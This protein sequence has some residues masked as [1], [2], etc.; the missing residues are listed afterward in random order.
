MSSAPRARVDVQLAFDQRADAAAGAVLRALLGVISGNLEGSLAGQDGEFLHQLRVSVRRSRTVQ[1]QLQ[2]VFPSRLLP[3]YR[4]EFRWLQRATGEARDLDVYLEG[5]AELCALVPD[6]WRGELEPLRMVLEH[7]RL[8]AHGEMTRALLSRRT[9]E[10]IG[11]WEML[12]ETLVELPAEDRRDARLPIGELAGRRIQRLY[13]RVV[14]LGE[15]IGPTS[16]AAELHELRKR[17]KELRY[18][19]E[20]FG[21]SLFAGE[22]VAAMITEVKALQQLL[23]RHQDR[24]VQ[25]AMLRSV[26]DEVAVLSGGPRALMAMGILVDRLADDARIARREFTERFVLLADPARQEAIGQTFG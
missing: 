4:S 5:F 21:L 19:L 16:P 15:R 22:T 11:D 23:G 10:L 24:E 6:A 25:M 26:A 20:L 14:R 13:E 9:S 18:M 8:A 3:G 2:T 1:R 12:L 17:G 7:W